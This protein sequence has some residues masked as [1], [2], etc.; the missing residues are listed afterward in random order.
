MLKSS[1]LTHSHSLCLHSQQCC[2]LRECFSQ[3]VEWE[4]TFLKTWGGGGETLMESA[5]NQLALFFFILSFL[6]HHEILGK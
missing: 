1:M 4:F 3:M 6:S 2:N 5:F